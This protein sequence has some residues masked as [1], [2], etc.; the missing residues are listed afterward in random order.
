VLR[1]P[2]QQRCGDGILSAPPPPPLERYSGVGTWV[3]KRYTR[4][5]A[6]ATAEAPPTA[7]ESHLRPWRC[8][9]PSRSRGRRAPVLSR[10]AASVVRAPAL[11]RR[12]GKVV[13]ASPGGALAAA[14][15][16]DEAV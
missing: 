5:D 9:G 3:S 2:G 8:A 6:G 10:V 1:G 13:T 11:G 16:A 4:R 12:A 7:R 15:E 14:R